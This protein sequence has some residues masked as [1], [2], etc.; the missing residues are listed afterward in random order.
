MQ[1]LGPDV[2]LQQG[3][4]DMDKGQENITPLMNPPQTTEHGYF[5]A[6]DTRDAPVGDGSM[7][8]GYLTVP[9]EADEQDHRNRN[10]EID[11]YLNYPVDDI[12]GYYDFDERNG[13]DNEAFN[14]FYNHENARADVS[15]MPLLFENGA[16]PDPESQ[17]ELRPPHSNVPTGGGTFP[18]G[19][20]DGPPNGY[21]PQHARVNAN[22]QNEQLERTQKRP[23]VPLQD[24]GL[25]SRQEHIQAPRQALHQN[26]RQEPLREP[27]QEQHQESR[28]KPVIRQPLE[29]SHALEA[30]GNYKELRLGEHHIPVQENIQDE[31]RTQGL[32][33]AN[34]ALSPSRPELERSISE[35]IATERSVD[36][37]LIKLM[38]KKKSPK[39]TVCSICDKFISRD[40]SRHIRIHN[41]VG[42]FQCVFPRNYCKHRTGK[43][44]RPYDYKKHLLNMHFNFDEP[45]AKTAP[46]LSDKLNIPG[47][48]VACG[49]KFVGNDWLD[50]HILTKDLSKKCPE[51]QRLERIYG[52]ESKTEN[53]V[54]ESVEDKFLED[55]NSDIIDEDFDDSN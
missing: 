55:R 52:E 33:R 16:R 12:G 6:Y 26:M 1:I 36:K 34:N 32:P 5:G 7:L 8:G 18:K 14:G 51:L 21:I 17:A 46:N 42:R 22:Q 28:S 41:E 44:N 27:S 38:K 20:H 48:C 4:G 11:N 54:E 50:H 40:F 2:Y 37:K 49:Q 25:D 24:G 23:V 15:F 47:L 39:G 19:I 30:E 43:F 29:G 45:S 53:T 10:S 13:L 35:P 31:L 9:P 3:T